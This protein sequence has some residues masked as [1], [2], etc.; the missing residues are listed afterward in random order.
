MNA[1]AKS[2]ALSA[3]IAFSS[4]G[5]AVADLSYPGD[6]KNGTLERAAKKN[7]CSL[8]SGGNHWTVKKGGAVV[9]QIPYSVKE[10][11]TCR[12]II[13]ALNAEC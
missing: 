5:F 9:T 7:G 10:N 3:A 4:P 8:E 13:K 2:V 12:E 11:G 6:C 1:L